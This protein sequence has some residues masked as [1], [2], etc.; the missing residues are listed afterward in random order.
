MAKTYD[1]I[2]RDI[3]NKIFSPVY[4]LM[5]E[6]DYYIDRL[7][8]MIVES[9][10]TAE[11][12]EF[13]LTVLF[14]IDTNIETVINSSRRYPMMSERQVVVVKEAQHLKNM[15]NLS[16]YLQKP[17]LSTVLV[18]CHKHG[19]IDK[20]KRL[21]SLIEKTG[22]MFESKRLKDSQL[23]AFIANY[24]AQSNIDIKIKA[25]QILADYVGSDLSRISAELDKLIIALHPGERTITPTHIE[26]VVGISKD[27][28][29]FELRSALIERDV[30]KANRI[31]KYFSEN[32]RSNPLVLTLS[33]LF[34]FFSNLM[35]AYYSIDKSD[36]GIATWLGLRM[37]WAAKD[38]VTAMRC[39]SGTKTLQIIRAIREC[40]AKSK[41]VGNSSTPDGELLRELV[42]FILH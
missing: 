17:L 19:S 36:R 7:A 10:L 20:R 31:V 40:D 1:D 12:R 14:G 11:E 8:D 21:A 15:D 42:F 4:Y 33:V 38:Y 27:Y 29:N 41:G 35:L 22:I 5:G 2:V 13:N 30:L 9:A 32:P 24:L 23:P 6:E 28:N 3:K 16:Y 26:R 25:A 39:Y 18:I 37:P 34:S